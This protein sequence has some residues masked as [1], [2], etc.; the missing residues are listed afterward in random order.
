MRKRAAASQKYNSSFLGSLAFFFQEKRSAKGQWFIISAVVVSSVFFAISLLM[1]DYFLIDSSYFAGL[2]N[3]HY[4]YDVVQQFD[5]IVATTPSNVSCTNLT[6]RLNELKAVTEHELASR[7]L[8][9]VLD[10]RI[11]NSPCATVNTVRLDFLV[12]RES[13]ILYNLTSY[14]SPSQII[15]AA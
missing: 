8:L 12:A 6:T 7:G 15:G 2:N 13:E 14:S 9:A 1:K 11:M 3:D 4:F 10:Y 5:K